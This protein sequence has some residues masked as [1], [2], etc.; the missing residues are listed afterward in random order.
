[1]N[2]TYRQ[3]AMTVIKSSLTAD[4]AKK[5]VCHLVSISAGLLSTYAP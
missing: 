5:I 1:M 4:F 3:S 2:V